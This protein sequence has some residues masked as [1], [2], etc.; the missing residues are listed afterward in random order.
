MKYLENSSDQVLIDYVNNSSEKDYGYMDC[1]FPAMNC[2]RIPNEFKVLEK[3][4]NEYSDKTSEFAYRRDINVSKK[5]YLNEVEYQISF[6]R[7]YFSMT[8][9]SIQIEIEKIPVNKGLSIINF[10]D[11][12][13]KE[14]SHLLHSIILDKL[15]NSM[16]MVPSSWH[17]DDSFD[18]LLQELN[19][20]GPLMVHGHFH[21]I[22]YKEPAK[23]KGV[24]FGNKEVY[25]YPPG[26]AFTAINAESD[27]H[28]IVLV[29]AKR[30]IKKDL[31]FYINPSEA[32]PKLLVMSYDMLKTNVF[33]IH[34]ESYVVEGVNIPTN[35]RGPFLVAAKDYSAIQ[36]YYNPVVNY[37]AGP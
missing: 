21:A 34:T 3:A 18:L 20:K 25:Q 14:L 2:L 6:L 30:G 5:T 22:Y 12:D 19:S 10:E 32:N 13:G 8:N 37:I 11:K 31:V 28:A 4:I 15:R 35:T 16:E 29:G 26:S 1:W 24:K 36:L 23:F 27:K 17:P 33:N 7:K 9:D